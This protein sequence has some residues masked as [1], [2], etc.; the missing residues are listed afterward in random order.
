[1]FNYPQCSFAAGSDGKF[2]S[3][4]ETQA[5]CAILETAEC[6]EITSFRALAKELDMHRSRLTR[7]CYALGIMDDVKEA[8]ANN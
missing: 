3:A 4:M 2:D 1:M 5:C 8:L 6:D 7:T